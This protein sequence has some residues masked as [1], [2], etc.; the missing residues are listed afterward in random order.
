MNFAKIFHILK[1]AIKSILHKMHKIIP[2]LQ[3]MT[4]TKYLIPPGVKDLWKDVKAIKIQ[5]GGVWQR[6]RLMRNEQGNWV[7]KKRLV[8]KYYNY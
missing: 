8:K 2:Q 5:N 6:S 3:T 7:S 4:K 1:F